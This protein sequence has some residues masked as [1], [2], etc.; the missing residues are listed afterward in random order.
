MGIPLM[1]KLTNPEVYAQLSPAPQEDLIILGP[2]SRPLE[3]TPIAKCLLK[4]FKLAKPS[5]A[6][7]W[8]LLSASDHAEASPHGSAWYGVPHVSRTHDRINL[9]FLSTSCGCS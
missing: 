3:T 7:P 8:L 4:L 9:V 5:K 1:C 6:S 2:D